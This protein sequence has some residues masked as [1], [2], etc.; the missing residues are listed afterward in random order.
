MAS[1]QPIT[2]DTSYQENSSSGDSSN[3]PQK[4]ES[5]EEKVKRYAREEKAWADALRPYWT[6]MTKNEELYEFYKS[7]YTE[8]ASNVALNTPFAIIESQIAKENQASLL[9]NVQAEGENGMAEFEKWVA[10]VVKGTMEDKRVARIKGTFRKKRERFSR[11]LKVVGNAVAEVAYCYVTQVVD[12]K[13][14]TVADNPYIINRS[15]RDLIFNPSRQFDNSNVYYVVDHMRFQ[16]MRDQEK[17]EQ[18]DKDGKV[19]TS[20]RFINLNQLEKSMGKSGSRLSD[21]NDTRYSSGDSKVPKKI[22]AVKIVTRWELKPAGWTRCVYANDRVL[23]MPDEVDPYRIGGHNLLLAMRYVIEGRP[24]A[25]G[26]MDPI[27]KPVRAQDTI[28]NQKIEIVNKYLRGSYIAGASIDI[29]AATLVMDQ[30]G[31]MS[32]VPNDITS[33]PVITPPAAAFQQ[34][35]ELQTAIERASRWSPLDNG[36]PQSGQGEGTRTKGGLIAL[37]GAAE[38]NTESQI[39]DIE[40]MLLEPYAYM[41]L[42]MKSRYMAPDETFDALVDGKNKEWVKVTKGILS[43]TATLSDFVTAGIVPQ[44]FLDQVEGQTLPDGREISKDLVVFDVSWLLDIK[45]SNE[46]AADRQNKVTR[47]QAIIEFGVEKLG[48]QFDPDRTMEYLADKE[49]ASEIK[50]LLLSPQEKQMRAQAQQRAQQQAAQTHMQVESAIKQA[51]KSTPAPSQTNERVNVN[52]TYK[53]APPDVQRE[54]ESL[55]GLNPSML[56]PQVAQ[57]LKN[58]LPQPPEPMAQPVGAGQGQ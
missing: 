47:E 16:D 9:V 2:G 42:M 57:T 46:S 25:Y 38:P 37:Q 1:E 7:E 32:G 52:V 58:P 20:G 15:W 19:V 48:A 54:M 5:Q 22:E 3:I 50:Q 30:G 53:D 24:Y 6:Q 44:D 21:D 10:S 11:S 43:G 34:T 33:F 45:L 55:A 56:H 8:T 4:G 14:K 49:D 41:A 29:D 51:G 26:E 36:N 23:V 12:G 17:T 39:D 28:V 27:Y 31:I 13:K 40:D 18:K 35:E